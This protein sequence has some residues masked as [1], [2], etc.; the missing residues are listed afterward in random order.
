MKIFIAGAG[1][2]GQGIAL[3][4]ARK[5]DVVLYDVSEQALEN[6]KKVIGEMA[7]R[8]KIEGE[9]SF[10]QNME[11]ARTCDLVIEAVVES[12]EVKTEVLKK[13][14]KLTNAPLCS[15]TSVICVNDIAER[16]DERERFL[17]VHWMN[18]PYVMPLVE[19]VLSK[20]TDQ[21]VASFVDNLLKDLGKEVVFCMNQSIV[22]R[23]NAAVLSEASKMI[24]EGVRVEDID[25]VW[26]FHLGILYTLFGPMG[27][28][29]Y[30]GLDVV[31]YASLYLYQRFRD[32]KF[33]PSH[34]L[35]EKVDKGEL[36]V[37]TGKGIYEYQDIER[38]YVER[39]ERIEKMLKFLLK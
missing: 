38:A 3:D 34:W 16:L 14:E 7:K 39:V 13:I 31:Y 19:V 18:P 30:I 2:M 28:V 23:F 20:Y 10:T 33:K 9:I 5:N 1:L 22:N 17:G 36:G 32:E 26:R 21:K 35:L 24:E 27:N 4:V 29:D 8:V 37:K 15:N 25:K 12:L 11:E 6:A